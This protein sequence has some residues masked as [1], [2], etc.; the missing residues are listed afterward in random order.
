M[1]INIPLTLAPLIVYN[2]VAFGFFGAFAGDPW[3]SPVMT[4]P[5]ISDARFT[6]LS[7]DIFIVAGLVFLFFEILKATRRASLAIVDHL[8]S[9][10]V[11]VAYLIEFLLVAR[12]ATSVF[13][14]LMVISFIDMIAG[15]TVT[16]RTVA[17]DI[18][19]DRG[20]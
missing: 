16:I 18:T 8:I 6:L 17:R 14:I 15:Y 20:E 11:F 9:T 2:L 13:F 7:G 1:F 4:V 19:Y 5:M 12:A 10:F 3:V